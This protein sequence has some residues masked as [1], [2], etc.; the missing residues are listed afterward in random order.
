[1]TIVISERHTGHP[2][3][4]TDTRMAHASQKRA[5][6]HGTSAKPPRGAT[7]Q[8]SQKSSDAVASAA[9]VES[10]VVEVVATGTGSCWSLDGFTF[11]LSQVFRRVNWRFC[12]LYSAVIIRQVL[13]C[14]WSPL[15]NRAV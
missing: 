9:V 13:L 7:K 10:D 5:C 12:D 11:L 14:S 4:I 15:F 6:P 1:M 8:T 3:F 2:P